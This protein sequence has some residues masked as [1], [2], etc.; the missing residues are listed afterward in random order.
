MS[1]QTQIQLQTARILNVPLQTY[2]K[3]FSF[4]VNGEEFKTSRII[5][6]L[7]S[8]KICSFHKVDPTIISFIVNTQS[9]GQFSRILGLST[10]SIQS[11]PEEE[12][13]FF[14][15]VIEILGND[16]IEIKNA[17]KNIQITE[18]NVF[19]LLQHHEKLGILFSSE[20][21]SEVEF[22]SSHFFSLC[23]KCDDEL[24]KLRI[25]TLESIIENLNLHLIDENQLLKVINGLYITDRSYARLYAHVLF[26]NVEL[27][28][29]DEFLNIFDYNDLSLE[30]WKSISSRLR[31][32]VKKS[33]DERPTARYAD[34]GKL[35][36]PKNESDFDG[37]LKY[38]R[39]QTN[40]NIESKVNITAS[41]LDTGYPP[42]NT[43]IYEDKSKIFHADQSEPNP[44]ICFEFKENRVSPTN[45]QI[46]SK[47]TEGQGGCHP[48][49]WVIEG[50]NDNFGWEKLDEQS[51][52]SIL[53]GRSIT[54]LFSIDNSSSKQFRFIRMKLTDKAWCGSHHLEFNSF[55]LYGKLI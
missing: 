53:N 37:I 19:S 49:S 47:H 12:L 17:E 35:F 15:E 9:K 25:D 52:C 38:L 51:N 36:E 45:Y 1:L 42:S 16:S 23:E 8:P 4:I 27:S 24:K 31:Q 40:N 2:G 54:H 34:V 29:I 46:R 14:S 41:V 26:E 21:V 55:E 3:D 33:N 32:T 11:I 44:W 48:K 13:E 6:D 30:S 50:S 28:A 22:I 43:V 10:F 7:I 39:D 18:E 20:I 5:S